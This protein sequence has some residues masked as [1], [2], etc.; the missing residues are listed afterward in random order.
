VLGGACAFASLAP[1]FIVVAYATL[2][3]SRRDLTTAAAVAGQLINEVVNAA[4]KRI[5]AVER[6]HMHEGGAPLHPHA[7][8]YGMPSNHAQ[9]M[10]Y[11][12]AFLGVWAASRWHVGRPWRMAT[13]ALLATAAAGVAASR[14]YL[15][16]HSV[17]QVVAGLAIGA[18]FAL[19][20]TAVVRH[21]LEPMY[22]TL[23]QSGWAR[24]ALVRDTRACPDVLTAEYHAT[25]A[26]AR[27]GKAH[28]S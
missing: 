18:A 28:P 17:D 9:F 15:R 19:A 6:P 8:R 1:I 22:P 27:A 24:W 3:A 23:E 14:V 26:F 25:A 21:W 20:W 10:G 2:L 16:Y 5:I 11:T 12:A 4:L 7:P 13:I